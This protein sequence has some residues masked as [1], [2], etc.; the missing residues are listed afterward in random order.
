MTRWIK[1][2]D[3]LIEFVDNL[4]SI[5]KSLEEISA[6]NDTTTSSKANYLCKL[7][8]DSAFVMD[9]FCLK[10]IMCLTRPLSI[11]PQTKNVDVS[12][13]TTK[14]KGLGEILGDKR[15]NADLNFHTILKNVTEMMTKLGTGN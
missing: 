11:L 9:I 2:Y 6:W 4:P 14:I 15:N 8:Q 10:D 5:L 12:S 7:I 13:A 1:R 3:I